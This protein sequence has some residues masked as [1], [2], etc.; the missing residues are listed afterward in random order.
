MNE[1]SAG[2]PLNHHL[3]DA[4]R[5]INNREAKPMI[6]PV[7]LFTRLVA[8]LKSDIRSRVQLVRQG[9]GPTSR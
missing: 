1:I 4:A 2:S 6:I 8:Q 9:K 5:A 3:K 7:Q